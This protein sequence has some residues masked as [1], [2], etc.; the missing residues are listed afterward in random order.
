MER[1]ARSRWFQSLCGG[2]SPLTFPFGG[3]RPRVVGTLLRRPAA[4]GMFALLVLA[5]V[6]FCAPS[7]VLDTNCFLTVTCELANY[8]DSSQGDGWRFRTGGQP[9]QIGQSLLVGL[10]EDA[11]GRAVLFEIGRRADE[12]FQC[13]PVSD[14]GQGYRY[15]SFE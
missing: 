8:A 5:N 10:P 1:T 2:G 13:D 15:Y 7:W 12:A 9:A 6:G 3:M 14:K 11:S 4:K